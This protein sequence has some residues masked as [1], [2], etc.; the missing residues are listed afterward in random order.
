MASI[1]TIPG[2]GCTNKDGPHARCPVCAPLFPLF[3]PDGSARKTAPSPSAFSGMILKGLELAGADTRGYS[4][5]CARRNL[6]T[7]QLLTNISPPT[8][9][10]LGDGY[11]KPVMAL[12][13]HST[14]FGSVQALTAAF[15]LNMAPSAAAPS[16]RAKDW[17]GWRAVLAWGT[18]RGCLDRL[19]LKTLPTLKA[20]IW[21][22]FLVNAQLQ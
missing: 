4:G 14:A 1:D 19:L 16:T 20:V 10:K 6:N 17:A 9:L 3:L 11:W 5:V 12:L 22:S 18:A 21:T 2:Q 13:S 7:N 15:D 8:A